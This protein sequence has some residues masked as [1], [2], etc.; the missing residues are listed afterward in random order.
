MKPQEKTSFKSDESGF[1]FEE[2]GCIFAGAGCIL[3]D[4]FHFVGRLYLKGDE[5]EQRLMLVE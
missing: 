1:T 2:A 5:I 4:G 3:R